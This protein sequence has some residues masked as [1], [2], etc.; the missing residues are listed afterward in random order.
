MIPIR[1]EL[2]TRRF[3]VVTVLII[4]LNILIFFWQVLFGGS[5]DQFFFQIGLVPAFLWGRARPL[6][7]VLNPLTT[8]FTSQFVHGNLF[9]LLFNMLYLWI[10]GNNVE[11]ILG[12]FQFL[13][14]YLACGLTAGLVH[15]LIFPNSLLPV[16]GASGA[17]AGVMGG[18]LVFF[19]YAR[20]VVM[21]FWGFFVQFVRV[22]ALVLLGFWILLQIVYGLFSL[23]F[24][25]YGGVAWFAHLGG[26]ALGALWSK[27]VSVRLYRHSYW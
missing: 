26:F 10:F 19:P 3:P 11:D 2:P 5:S 8:L 9:H 14:F 1:D 6:L 21:V 15:A 25:N 22:P 16:V 20:V 12:H 23:A 4:G 24:P 17:I 13:F 18:Y 7:G 27:I